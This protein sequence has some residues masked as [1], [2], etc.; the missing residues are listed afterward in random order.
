MNRSGTPTRVLGGGA[1]LPGIVARAW[2]TIAD[3][4]GTPR[5]HGFCAKP[6]ELYE[7]CR[8]CGDSHD[9][10][11]RHAPQGRCARLAL[12]LPSLA[13]RAWPS[14]DWWRRDGA[15]DPRR[16]AWRREVPLAL[17]RVNAAAL[18]PEAALTLLA[19]LP[20]EIDEVPLEL[21]ASRPGMRPFP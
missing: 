17:W 6:M 21:P 20:T 7:L 10:A 2:L 18:E 5:S 16:L 1:K 13:T 3:A 8:A 12:W 14:P 11:W 9:R 19:G 15:N 4:N